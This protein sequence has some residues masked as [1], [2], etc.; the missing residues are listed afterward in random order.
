[1]DE[2]SL[3]MQNFLLHGGVYGSTDNRVA[4]QQKKR[5]GRFGYL[6]SR[7]FVPYSQLKRYY[8]ILEK[9]RWL[10]PVMQVRRWFMLLDPS[11]AKM[12]TKE[13]SVNKTIDRNYV[14]EMAD[15]QKKIGL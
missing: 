10:M 3:Q 5:G 15:F 1:M 8:P 6:I 7:M 11:V 9:Y 12:A 14:K 2:L 13:L 4:I